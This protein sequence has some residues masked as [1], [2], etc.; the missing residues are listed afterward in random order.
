MNSTSQHAAH[1][2][3]HVQFE[4]RREWEDLD[5]SYR[6]FDPEVYARLQQLFH[7]LID[8][9]GRCDESF[10]ENEVQ[11]EMGFAFENRVSSHHWCPLTDWTLTRV[12]K[13]QLFGGLVETVPKRYFRD[14][15][16]QSVMAVK[17][18][19]PRAAYDPHPLALQGS[20]E[21]LQY[22]AAH[23]M[24]LD[25]ALPVELGAR[26]FNNEFWSCNAVK[27]GWQAFKLTPDVPLK[28]RTGHSFPHGGDKDWLYGSAAVARWIQIAD[29]CLHSAG[30]H[31]IAA[32]L[33]ALSWED[34]EGVGVKRVWTYEQQTWHETDLQLEALVKVVQA[35]GPAISQKLQ[36][37]RSA[38][39]ELVRQYE[40]ARQQWQA[41]QASGQ[42]VGQIEPTIHDFIDDHIREIYQHFCAF[43]QSV[44]EI[45][46][47][48][49]TEIIYLQNLIYDY[50]MDDVAG[51]TDIWHSSGNHLSIR[52]TVVHQ[53]LTTGTIGLLDAIEP[54]VVDLLQFNNQW[55][56]EIMEDIHKYRRLLQMD[57]N[58][59]T[60]TLEFLKPEY[61]NADITLPEFAGVLPSRKKSWILSLRNMAIRE[62]ALIEEPVLMQV[63]ERWY[64]IIHRQ[65]DFAHDTGEFESQELKNDVEEAVQRLR[66][67]LKSHGISL[68]KTIDNANSLPSKVGT[69]FD[70]SRIPENTGQNKEPDPQPPAPPQQPPAQK[71]EHHPQIL[72]CS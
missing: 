24:D 16:W 3:H 23:A 42:V 37:L 10:F 12:S 14:L 28:A 11:A 69:V 72:T 31:V 68:D 46:R 22:P 58:H 49:T 71:R 38:Q 4:H 40:Q 56:P 33:S 25:E 51:R 6:N 36:I 20:S 32:Y 52:M 60:H 57:H 59:I 2:A 17:A 29:G 9:R 48:L 64:D 39:P 1:F 34:L 53:R 35:A 27:Y 65:A 55:P 43:I 30:H 19:W 5:P 63:I 41:L 7:R 45:H 66:A 67:G 18:Q 26:F 70:V 62:M 44:G 50:L 61:M 54:Y 15:Q 13:L 8:P 47:C 21:F